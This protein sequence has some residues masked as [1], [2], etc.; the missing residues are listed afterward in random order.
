[1]IWYCCAVRKEKYAMMLKMI[2]KEVISEIEI[3]VDGR[4]PGVEWE[5]KIYMFEMTVLAIVAA[6]CCYT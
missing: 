4:S 5:A 3:V 6:G 2:T 1:M